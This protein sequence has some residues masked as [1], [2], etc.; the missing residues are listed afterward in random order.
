MPP[1]SVTSALV[2]PAGAS[3]KVKVTSELLSPS[4]SAASAMS[5]VTVGF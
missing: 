5:T 1:T 3:L 2:K 4:L